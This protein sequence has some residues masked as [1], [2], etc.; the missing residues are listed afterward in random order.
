LAAGLLLYLT[1]YAILATL[2][3]QNDGEFGNIN[4]MYERIVAIQ[5]I[6]QKVALDRPYSAPWFL[7]P[8]LFLFL[9]TIS[10]AIKRTL[11]AFKRRK[12][13]GKLDDLTSE[14]LQK[15]GVRLVTSAQTED[16][17]LPSM[18]KVAHV[19][20]E[21]GFSLYTTDDRVIGSRAR[22]ALFASPIFH[23]ILV[24]SFLV[25]GIGQLTRADISVRVPLN[26]ETPFSVDNTLIE[27]AG[28]LYR[29]PENRYQMLVTD[30][31]LGFSEDG[32]I[33]TMAPETTLMDSQG[34][35]IRHQLVY[36]NNTIRAWPLMIHAHDY[37]LAAF[38]SF[39]NADGSTVPVTVTMQFVSETRDLTDP[40]TFEMSD[41]SENPLFQIDF[42][43]TPEFE[44]GRMIPIRMSESKGHIK[45][46]D[47]YSNAIVI[48]EEIKVGKTVTAV[49]NDLEVSFDE[50]TYYAQ[51]RVVDDWSVYPLYLSLILSLIAVGVALLTTPMFLVIEQSSDENSLFAYGRIYRPYSYSV[52]EM[53]ELISRALLR[54]SRE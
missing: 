50:L 18:D 38:F 2:L 46:V 32:I 44:N 22:W 29:F 43:L 48:D 21:E 3:A 52:D 34:R 20:E 53:Y 6:L 12:I 11:L 36:P 25:V 7:I 10:C 15:R 28:L 33:R 24:F 13:V 35:I 47:L 14:T 26:K 45:I 23:W 17:S 31:N 40:I 27:N 41:S 9:C 4:G 54:Q 5:P 51:F 49:T 37:G 1:I 39:I 42:I 16:G 19:L 8:L 30:L